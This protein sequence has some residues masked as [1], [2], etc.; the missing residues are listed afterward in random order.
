MNKRVIVT[1]SDLKQ[2]RPT[3]ELDGMRWEPFVT[4]AQE[5]DLRPI[6]GDGLFYDF[7]TKF[8]D[9]GD[10]MYT[11]YQE[12]INGKAY[13][14]NGQTIYF[15]GVK[16]MVGY[17]ALAR[18][19]QNN[20]INITRFGVVTKVTSQSQN[21]DPQVLRQVVNELRS[22]AIT[23]KNQVDQFLLENQSTYTLYI[24]SDSAIK[25]SF[26]MFKG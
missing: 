19:V 11:A 7:M 5:Q 16:P 3:A 10:A 4:E 26:R 18:L 23:Y 12:L 2:L 13:T 24:G 6:L 8:H 20:P 22:N 9:T 1:L 15:D 14:Y 17:F 21:V 25:T